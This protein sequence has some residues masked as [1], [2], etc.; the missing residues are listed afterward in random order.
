MPGTVKV[1][2]AI[3]YIHLVPKST[4]GLT[5]CTSN[6]AKIWRIW[7]LSWKCLCSVSR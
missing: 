6:L 2:S 3:V 5:S 4:R 7:V 1:K